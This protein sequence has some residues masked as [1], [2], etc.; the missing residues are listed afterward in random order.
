MLAVS[1]LRTVWNYCTCEILTSCCYVVREQVR[2]L[3]PQAAQAWWQHGHP[4]WAIY[5]VDSEQ[6]MATGALDPAALPSHDQ[7]IAPL[8]GPGG[9]A[10]PPMPLNPAFASAFMGAAQAGVPNDMLLRALG[11]NPFAGLAG[12]PYMGGQLPHPAGLQ[13][14]GS[15]HTPFAEAAGMGGQQQA[16]AGQQQQQA[17]PGQGPPRQNGG[18]MA[19]PPPQPGGANASPF[20]RLGMAPSLDNMPSLNLGNLQAML[21]PDFKL[22]ML[23][24]FPSLP[25]GALFYCYFAICISFP[26]E[27]WILL[28]VVC[29]SVRLHCSLPCVPVVVSNDFS[30]CVN[31]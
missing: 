20:G 25:V 13:L 10:P 11:G 7:I 9:A 15:G 21:G 1:L 2:A 3:Q 17:G 29:F 5:P 18:N 14:D 12:M 24:G 27:E 6:F 23:A 22:P 4:G 26:L 30:R 28:R 16:A 31:P 19:P 8:A